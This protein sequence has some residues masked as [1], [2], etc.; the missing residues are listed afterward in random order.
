MWGPGGRGFPRRCWNHMA[1]N[2]P[3][4][5]RQSDVPVY[6]QSLDTWSSLFTPTMQGLQEAP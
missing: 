6:P 1:A 2:Q 3:A 4:R 5:A